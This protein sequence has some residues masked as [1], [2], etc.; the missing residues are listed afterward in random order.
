[1]A[2][3]VKNLWAVHIPRMTVNWP[4][5]CQVLTNPCCF[6]NC[7]LHQV[8]VRDASVNLGVSGTFTTHYSDVRQNI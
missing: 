6:F 3:N 8:A 7:H 4:K 2:E 1:M 5:V